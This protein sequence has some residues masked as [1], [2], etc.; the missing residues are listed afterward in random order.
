LNELFTWTA[1]V[2]LRGVVYSKKDKAMKNN[3][4]GLMELLLETLDVEAFVKGVRQFDNV[5][6]KQ[7]LLKA[8]RE[9]R[10]PAIVGLHGQ[11]RA[12]SAVQALRAAV[13]N[14]PPNRVN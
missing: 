11:D 12:K 2:H 8:R 3:T 4:N 6:Q 10:K 7:C 14:A 5:T 13:E 1:D 9:L